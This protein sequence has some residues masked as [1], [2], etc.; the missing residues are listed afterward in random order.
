MRRKTIHETFNACIVAAMALVGT[1]AASSA[2]DT[3]YRPLAPIKL[4]GQ[5]VVQALRLDPISR[6]LFAGGSRAIEVIDIDAGKRVGTVE[7]GGRASAIALGTDIG[8]GFASVPG[9]NAVVTF[10]LAS[11][12]VLSTE[13]LSG[14]PGGM[15]Y[16]PGTKQV[17]VSG[18]DGKLTAIVGTT[19]KVAGTVAVGGVLKQAAVDTRGGLFVADSAKNAIHVISTKDLKVLGQIP[20]WPAEK[21][22]GLALDNKER[23]LYVAAENN[24]MVIVDPDAGQMIGQVETNGRGSAGIAIQYMPARLAWLVMPTSDGNVSVIKN[25]KLTATLE[26][27]VAANVRSDAVDIDP[28]SGRTFLGGEAEVLVLSR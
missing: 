27:T 17:F 9:E 12:K 15:T 26:S 8:R 14:E 11:L 10:D 3:A 5:G 21:P 13:K 25:A 28:R 1:I 20:S 4:E 22:T 18:K 6:R 16:D 24:R 19:G 2:A 23:R 7:L